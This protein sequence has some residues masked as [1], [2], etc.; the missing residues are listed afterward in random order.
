MIPDL[1]DVVVISENIFI[2]AD[3]YKTSGMLATSMQTNDPSP[4]NRQI[5]VMVRSS[6]LSIWL[7]IGNTNPNEK[8]LSIVCEEKC[9]L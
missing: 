1:I 6:N 2:T 3:R 7:N 9:T 8:Q 5:V 4:L